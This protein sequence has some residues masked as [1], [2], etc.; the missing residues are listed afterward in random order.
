MNR[1]QKIWLCVVSVMFLGLV[2]F[3]VNTDK[4]MTTMS[5]SKET[6]QTRENLVTESDYKVSDS[7]STEIVIDSA[8]DKNWGDKAY[9]SDGELVIRQAGS[10]IMSGR[11]DGTLIIRAYDDQQVHLILNGFEVYSSGT[12]ALQV[13]SASKVIVT[14]AEESQN[15]LCDTEY[16]TDKEKNSC[17][18]SVADLTFNGTGTVNVWGY[19]QDAIASKGRIKVIRGSY[20]IRAVDDAIRGRD[21]VVI[22]GGILNLQTEGTGIKST[23]TENEKKGDINVQGGE[24]TIIAGEHAIS[25]AKNLEIVGCKIAKQTVLDDFVC[26][27]KLILSEECINEIYE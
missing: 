15:I 9:Y 11:M 6:T 20:A 8:E 12:P 18:Y 19:Y 14:A 27:G 4:E 17:I 21:G 2:A 7:G 23:N 24:L 25:A 13:E 22:V 1:E 10:Y 5:E 16:R 26:Q 3:Y